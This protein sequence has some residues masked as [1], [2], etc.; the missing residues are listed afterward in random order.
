M[1]KFKKDRSEN[2]KI[3]GVLESLKI[4]RESRRRMTELG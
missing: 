3:N 4:S 1:N 2:I